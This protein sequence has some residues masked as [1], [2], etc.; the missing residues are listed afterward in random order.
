MRNYHSSTAIIKGLQ[1]Y[2]ISGLQV[3]DVN[4]AL[5]MVPLE[6]SLSP[7]ILYLLD[8][9]DNYATY[10]Q[11]MQEAPGIP[12]LLPHIREFKRRGEHGLDGLF[13][14]LQEIH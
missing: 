2:K 8:A 1:D 6:P 11:R 12:F 5:G 7:N 4:V 10:R 9:S 3:S 14:G 13:Q